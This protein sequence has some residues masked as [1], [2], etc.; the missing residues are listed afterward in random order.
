MTVDFA[1]AG[2]LD[3][4]QGRARESRLELLR[5]LHDDGCSMEDLREAAAEDRLALLPVERILSE[6]RRHSLRDSAALT[7]LS[8]DYLLQN[9]MAIGLQRPD[10]DT[11]VYDDDQLENLRVLETLMQVGISE[12]QLHAEG[13]VMGQAARRMAE[14][15]VDGMGQALARP[16]DTEGDI[17][18]R[19]YELA[20]GLLPNLDRMVGGVLRLHLLDVVRREAVGHV[21]RIRGEATGGREV[22]VAFADVAGFTAMS[23]RVGLDEVGKVAARFERLVTRHASPPVRLVKV[24]GDGALL[25][26]DEADTLLGAVLGVVGEAE[27]AALPPVHAGVHHGRALR[28]AGDWYGRTVNLAARL[29]GAAPPGTVLVTRAVRDAANAFAYDE[30]PPLRLRGID[31]PVP[32]LR[33]SIA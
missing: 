25:V 1:A 12:E 26:S 6:H 30:Q 21:E 14:A 27:G 10:P 32:V 18:L 13:R 17:A 20:R 28:S 23:E 2:L 11:P 9:H 29:C 31:A 3:G 4:L 22:A 5:R 7:G 33:A 24:L 8:D 16:D 15:F 19:Y